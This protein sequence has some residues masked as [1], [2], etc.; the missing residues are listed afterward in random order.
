MAKRVKQFRYYGDGSILNS[1]MADSNNEYVSG[2]VFSAYYPILQLGIQAM[3]GTKFYLNKSTNP[4]MIGYTG[5]YELDLNGQI[6]ISALN[7]DK[8]S[9][10][11]I[12]ELNNALLIVDVVYEDNTEEV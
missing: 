6:E 10:D 7:F 5:I 4:V 2:A 12:N 1:P 11:Q 8:A 3:P 9:M